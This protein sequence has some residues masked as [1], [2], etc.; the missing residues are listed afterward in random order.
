MHDDSHI[1]SPLGKDNLHLVTTN[2]KGPKEG[3][4]SDQPQPMTQ[5]QPLRQDSESVHLEL[6]GDETVADTE[7]LRVR[8]LPIDVTIVMLRNECALLK[9]E[10]KDLDEAISALQATVLPD[11]ILLARFK[12][13]KLNLRDRIAK[14]EDKIRPD[15]IA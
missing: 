3:S 9:Q 7:A 13:K 14:I 6:V 8:D 1:R 4:A 15:I 10:H 11:Q 5:R 12:R 2:G